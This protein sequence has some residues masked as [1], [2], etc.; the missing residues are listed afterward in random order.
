M[1]CFASSLVFFVDDIFAFFL[2]LRD[3]SVSVRSMSAWSVRVVH[4]NGSGCVGIGMTV[5]RS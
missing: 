2:R 5:V 1:W 3:S 4:V